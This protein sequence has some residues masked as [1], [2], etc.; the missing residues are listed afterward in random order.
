MIIDLSSNSWGTQTV[1]TVRIIPCQWV[2]SAK[3]ISTHARLGI[4]SSTWS[5]LQT[6]VWGTC[7]E[8]LNSC[9]L[10][11]WEF[12]YTWCWTY[13]HLSEFE[14]HVIQGVQK[15]RPFE[16]TS[17]LAIYRHFSKVPTQQQTPPLNIEVCSPD[18]SCGKPD[19]IN[20]ACYPRVN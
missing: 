9:T 11:I 2:Q 7:Y 1:D 15:M 13:F 8:I 14:Y 19:F 10:S 3:W 5:Q 12:E 16:M 17:P 20:P 18:C 6:Q 4:E